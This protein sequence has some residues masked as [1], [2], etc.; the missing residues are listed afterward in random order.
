[1]GLCR[2]EAVG[3]RSVAETRAPVSL[4]GQPV[5]GELV[6]H[7]LQVDLRSIAEQLAGCGGVLVPGGTGDVDV[8][9]LE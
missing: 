9:A 7:L 6:P 4:R 8:E 1:M 5:A 2:G 3:A